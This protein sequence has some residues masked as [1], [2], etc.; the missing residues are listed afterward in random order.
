MNPGPELG[1]APTPKMPVDF[2]PLQKVMGKITPGAPHTKWHLPR[3]AAPPRS[4]DPGPRLWQQ[5]AQQFSLAT[6]QITGVELAC[7]AMNQLQ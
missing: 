7:Q 2:L 1:L 5:R 3:C 4:A 6:D